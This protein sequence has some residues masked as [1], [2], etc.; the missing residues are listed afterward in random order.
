MNKPHIKETLI[1]HSVKSS[2]H[3]KLQWKM[4]SYVINVNQFLPDILTYHKIIGS[5]NNPNF[6]PLFYSVI[7]ILHFSFNKFLFCFHQH[8]K[9]NVNRQA[10]SKNYS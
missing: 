2:I 8:T 7:A 5:L 3:Y 9:Y 10:Q 6:F 1:A 4:F